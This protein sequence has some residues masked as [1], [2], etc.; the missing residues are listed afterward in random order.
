[1]AISSTGADRTAALHILTVGALGTL[2]FNVMG[3][4]FLRKARRDPAA[5]PRLP[6]GTVLIGAATV[7]RVAATMAPAVSVELLVVAA[8]CWTGA[9]LALSWLFA[10]SFLMRRRKPRTTAN[11]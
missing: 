10:G 5:E 3:A 8:A 2:T 11:A 1:M 9:F 6:W 4:T 7:S